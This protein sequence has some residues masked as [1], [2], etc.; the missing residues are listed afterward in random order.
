M[1]DKASQ[2]IKDCSG[3]TSKRKVYNVIHHASG[4]TT[5]EIRSKQGSQKV[6]FINGAWLI[7]GKV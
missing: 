1:P 6:S 5:G 4:V 3:N 2:T 7:L